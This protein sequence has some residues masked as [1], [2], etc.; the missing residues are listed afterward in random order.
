M[1]E[2]ISGC[3]PTVDPLHRAQ[4][5]SFVPIRWLGVKGLKLNC[6]ALGSR[7]FATFRVARLDG[8]G[9]SGE[10]FEKTT[11]FPPGLPP[12]NP[13]KSVLSQKL[14]PGSGG[15]W[16]LIFPEVQGPERPEERSP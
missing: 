1:A 12:E 14:G 15:L 4:P 11:I 7:R 6:S 2:G 10:P 13:E 3:P 5:G 16:F 9:W 8:G